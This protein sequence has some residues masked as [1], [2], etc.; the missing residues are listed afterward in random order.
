MFLIW[1]YLTFFSVPILH[2][3]CSGPQWPKDQS[4]ITE[5]IT[6]RTIPLVSACCVEYSYHSYPLQISRVLCEYFLE[7]VK[8]LLWLFLNAQFWTGI[9]RVIYYPLVRA[10][11]LT[12]ATTCSGLP[13]L[14]LG[15]VILAHFLYMLQANISQMLPV[16]DSL[17]LLFGFSSHK[18]T[19]PLNL[20]LTKP[21]FLSFSTLFFLTRLSWWE[22]IKNAY[23]L[24]APW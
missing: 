18:K 21:L 11:S 3:W 16:L 12:P 2:M 8:L 22:T 5:L 6:D 19:I 24:S 13:V 20:K 10:S 7:L 17:R 4:Q 14:S 9:S 1:E 15:L 23:L